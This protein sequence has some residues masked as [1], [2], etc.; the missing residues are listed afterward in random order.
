[1]PAMRRDAYGLPVTTASAS[2]LETYDQAVVGLLGWDASP[3][4][5]F[6]HATAQDPGFAVAHAG[7]AMCLFLEE[8]FTEAREAARAACAS[9]GAQTER[10]RRHVEAVALLVEG[11]PREGRVV[12]RIE[13]LRARVIELGGRRAQRDVCHDTLLEACFR[14]GDM[15]RAGRLLRER[16]ARR[17]D[18][19]WKTPAGRQVAAGVN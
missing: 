19:L 18:H 10:E 12:A 2:A 1:M 11:Q 8:R 15:E 3:L 5:L 4:D 16:V 17:P 14:A 7:P 9:A 6:R 13:P